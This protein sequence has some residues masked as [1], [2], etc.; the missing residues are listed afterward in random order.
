MPGISA[1]QVR[2]QVH[3]F[4]DAY[5]T[6]SAQAMEEMYFSNAI[7][8]SASARRSERAQLALARRLREFRDGNTSMTADIRSMDVQIVGNTAIA[9][10]DYQFSRSRINRNGDREIMD[11]PFALG[12][13]VFQPGPDGVARIVHEHFSA[14]EEAKRRVLPKQAAVAGA[15]KDQSA[16]APLFGGCQAADWMPARDAAV[17]AEDIRTEVRRYWQLYG[18]KSKDELEQMYFPS[19]IVFVAGVRRGELASLASARRAREFFGPQSSVSAQLG[20]VDVQ[21]VERDLAIASYNFHWRMVRILATRKRVDIEVPFG[22]ASYIFRKDDRGVLRIFHEHKSAAGQA[23]MK[24]L[25]TE[26]S[27]LAGKQP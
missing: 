15:N 21:I 18:N 4:W 2:A 3:R 11:V 24:D 13:Q 14:A 6:K 10:Y 26:E 23:V 8:F 9:T 16:M 20:S 25:P 19:A 17:S 12:T 27:A 7:V 5:C 22:R 1:E